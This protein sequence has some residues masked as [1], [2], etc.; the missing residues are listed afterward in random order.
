MGQVMKQNGFTL[1]E[2]LVSVVIVSALAIIAVPQYQ[3]RIAKAQTSEA[4]SSIEAQKNHVVTNIIKHGNCVG[5]DGAATTLKYGTLT[6]QGTLASSALTHSNSQVKTGCTLTYT[7]ANAGVSKRLQ[8]KKIVADIFGNG[9][10]SKNSGTN[11]G[12]ELV[13]IAFTTLAED[14]LAKKEILA[15]SSVDVAKDTA[16]IVEVGTPSG[17]A[18]TPTSTN[19]IMRSVRYCTSSTSSSGGIATYFC[20]YVSKD[21]G[22]VFLA[23]GYSNGKEGPM[24]GSKS[25]VEWQEKKLIEDYNASCPNGLCKKVDLD[26]SAYHFKDASGNVYIKS[27]YWQVMR[28]EGPVGAGFNPSTHWMTSTRVTDIETNTALATYNVW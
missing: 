6:T 23:L 1:V 3:T 17:G 5:K 10:L 12:T 16:E 13:P 8:G 27:S 7:F 9:V 21:T 25:N 24:S 14:A 28:F 11:L 4:M 2:A 26:P 22:R 15:A 19:P 20:Y 18:E